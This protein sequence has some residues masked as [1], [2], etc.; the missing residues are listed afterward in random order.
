MK[1]DEL[2]YDEALAAGLKVADATGVRAVH[3]RTRLPMIVF[4]MQ[5]EGNILRVVQGEK[6]GTLVSAG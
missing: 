5:P 3:A 1:F 6:I 2:T 4:G